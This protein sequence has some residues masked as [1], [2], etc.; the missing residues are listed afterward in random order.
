MKNLLFL[1]FLILASCSK[2]N[3]YNLSAN[4][5]I[6]DGEM[7]YL[8]Q[9]KENVP[10]LKDSINVLGGNFSFSDSIV[11]PEMY[12]LFFKNIRGNVPVVLE[13]GNIEMTVYKDSL[14][15]TIIKGT[16]SND[17]F[18][19][20]I[21]ESSSFINELNSIQNEINYNIAINDSL[22]KLDLEE[23]FIE[24]RKKLTDYEYD[25][26]SNKNDSYV[27]ALILQRMVFER[28]IDYDIADSILV[29]FDKSLFKTSP[30]IAVRGIIDNYKMSNTEA[31]RIGSF[32]PKFSGPGLNG[33]V[34][35]LYSIKSKYILIDFWASWC[36]PCRVEN[37]GLAELQSKY[38]DEDFTIL[39]VS[40]DMNM[41]SW[42]R[43]I[44]VDKIES[45]IHISNLKYFND[46]IAK[47]YDL[48]KEGIPS[49]FLINPERKIIARNIKGEDLEFVLNAELK[50]NE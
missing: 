16:K 21:D 23:Q 31:P 5:D 11:V 50:Y 27:S 19:Q 9:Y 39:G 34:I 7:V 26:M 28:S 46:P 6:P 33:E 20:Y 45:W 48:S 30:F 3:E 8:V 49:S 37:P 44:E 18:K 10:V 47:L 32:A 43:A 29:N 2:K 41:E 15:S 12:Y 25:F 17:D 36:A 38:S 22:I 24:M 42:K 14:R 13:P 4:S 40:L 35:S 1:S